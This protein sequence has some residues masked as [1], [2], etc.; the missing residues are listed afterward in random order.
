MVDF[1][2]QQCEVDLCIFVYTNANEEKIYIALYIN[3]FLIASENENDIATIKGL[4]AER[5]EM[6]DLGIAERFLGMEIKYGEDGSVKLHQEQYLCNLLKRHGMQDCNPISTPLDTSVKLTKAT[7]AEPLANSKEYASIVGGLMFAA[8]VTRPDIMCAVGQLSQFL[9]KP[10]SRH[11]LAAKRILRYLKGT[12]NL[13]IRYGHPVTPLVGFSDADWAGNLDTRRSTTGYVVMLNNG[14]VTWRSQRQPTVA[15]STMEA[16]YMAL[17][18]ATKELLWMRRF[19]T[20]LGYGNDD[21]VDL[22]TDNQSALALSKNP[23]SH[24]RAKH[25]DVRHHFVRDAIQDNVVWVQHI[26]TENIIADSL[27]KAL[28]REKHWRCTTRMGMC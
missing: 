5:F 9:N 22:F 8:C 11:L 12:L 7:D 28:G 20:E 6:K 4:L 13:G 17:T 10:T 2:F 19:L 14:A 3:D 16:E 18:E 21:P 24:A 15:L 27:T 23:V 25:I 26:P 1:D